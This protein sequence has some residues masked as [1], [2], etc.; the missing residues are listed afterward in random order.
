MIVLEVQPGLAAAAALTE[1][2]MVATRF[3]GAH[4]LHLKAGPRTLRIGAEWLY[5]ASPACLAAL[6]EFGTVLEPSL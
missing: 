2:K 5:D 3:P 6:G 1:I 4:V